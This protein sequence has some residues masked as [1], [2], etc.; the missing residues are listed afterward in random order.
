MSCCCSC[1]ALTSG[2]MRSLW[3]Q[4]EVKTQ[5]PVRVG[6]TDKRRAPISIMAARVSEDLPAAASFQKAIDRLTLLLELRDGQG[7]GTYC[8]PQPGK[9]PFAD[10]TDRWAHI[11]RI[12]AVSLLRAKTG[13]SREDIHAINKLFDDFLMNTGLHL[14][15]VNMEA[16][17][18]N[19]A[20]DSDGKVPPGYQV[21]HITA[22]KG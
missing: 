19:R 22:E 17:Y 1:T 11:R 16:G 18:R 12:Q 7:G 21:P 20:R 5:N 8:I 6:P 15:I 3:P 13:E 10:D 9:S 4:L 14:A 2:A